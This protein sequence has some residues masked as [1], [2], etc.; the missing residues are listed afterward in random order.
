MFI[1]TFR[2]SI[3]LYSVYIL[4]IESCNLVRFLE[5]FV[6]SVVV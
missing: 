4:F 3:S 1:L 6:V 5:G 2:F